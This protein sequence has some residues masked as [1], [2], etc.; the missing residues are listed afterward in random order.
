M[1]SKKAFYLNRIYVKFSSKSVPEW[2]A[3]IYEYIGL[4]PGNNGMLRPKDARGTSFLMHI[5]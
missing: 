1:E 2:S 5:S 3:F 4:Q